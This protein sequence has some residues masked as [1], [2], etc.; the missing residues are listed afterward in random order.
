MTTP[1][2]PPSPG[3]PISA[4]FFARLIAW[5]KS[6]QLVDGIGYR[7]HRTPNGTS[8]EIETKQSKSSVQRPWTF[9]V[10]QDPDS[11]DEDKKIGTWSN[12]IIQLGYT[13][14][15]AYDE[16]TKS[17]FALEI[18]DN[19]KSTDDGLYYLE[20]NLVERKFSIKHGELVPSSDYASGIV[21]VYIGKVEDKVQTHGIYTVPVIYEYV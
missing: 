20:A 1:P 5:V 6:G 17:P 21:N 14:F 8:L 3:K 4:S 2:T 10:Q 19:E 9:S 18:V 12:K 11:E 16:N 7:I 13:I 15:A